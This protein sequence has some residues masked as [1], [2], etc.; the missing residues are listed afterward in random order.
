M[1]RK[2]VIGERP[3]RPRA[4]PEGSFGLFDR[5]AEPTRVV[6]REQEAEIESEL[7]FVVS[8]KIGEAFMLARPGL[9]DQDSIV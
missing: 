9:A 8:K 3:G 2:I 6:A 4:G 7:Q 1:P 5:G